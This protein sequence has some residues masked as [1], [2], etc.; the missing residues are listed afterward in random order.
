MRMVVFRFRRVRVVGMAILVAISFTGCSGVLGSNGRPLEPRLSLIGSPSRTVTF[1]FRITADDFTPI[2]GTVSTD[3]AALISVPVGRNR[4]I[5]LASPADV[6]SGSA[7]F[8]VL[9][10]REN[11]VGVRVYPGPVFPSPVDQTLIQ[12]RDFNVNFSNLSS[13]SVR[14]WPLYESGEPD[15]SVLPSDM[16]FDTSGRLWVANGA[17]GTFGVAVVRDLSG[18]VVGT[19]FELIAAVGDVVATAIA[20]DPILGLVYYTDS[21]AGSMSLV[22]AISTSTLELT[23]FAIPEA[24]PHVSGIAVDRFSNVYTVGSFAYQIPSLRKYNSAGQL[25]AGPVPVYTGSNRWGYFNRVPQ[26]SYADLMVIDDTLLVI[27]ASPAVGEPTVFRFNLDLSFIE[28]FGT[29]TSG[30]PL[31]GQLWGPR[32]FV[33]TRPRGAV[34]VI[35]QPD[36]P[37]WLEGPLPEGR[38]VDLN[39]GRS[40][41]WQAY[42]RGAFGF[43]DTTGS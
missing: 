5:N 32:R 4:Q 1:D 20:Y 16:V 17:S 2:T 10:G 12:F 43:F 15:D 13:G 38:I 9:W 37:W 19:N 25:I 31:D 42:G 29:R 41:G 21:D 11:Q 26:P 33:A 36:D 30:N 6:Y 34:I 14:S 35:D 27:A 22:R 40:S 39:G 3:Q 18:D 23:G 8:D 28:S 24:V 7:V